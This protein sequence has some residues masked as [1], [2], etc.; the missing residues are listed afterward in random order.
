DDRGR[1]RK[2]ARSIFFFC[3]P[4]SVISLLLL[5][6]LRGRP[7]G[8]PSLRGLYLRRE[9]GPH[10]PRPSAGRPPPQAGEV[11]KEANAPLP[12][13]L[14]GGPARAAGRPRTAPA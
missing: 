1:A 13:V 5:P 7:G 3:R 11:K 6:R 4:S 10:P 9:R 12:P 14:C 8:G 2:R